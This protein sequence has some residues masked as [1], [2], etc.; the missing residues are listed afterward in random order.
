M[1]RRSAIASIAGAAAWLAGCD[2]ARAPDTRLRWPSLS[3][4]DLA[5]RPATLAGTSRGARVINV[6]AL[7]CPPCR[8]ELP[9]LERLKSVLAPLAI[10]VCTVALAEDSFP[11]REYLAQHA[12]HLHCVVLSPRMPV[13]AELDVKVLPQTF[14]VAADGGVL[15][16]WIGAREWDSPAVREQLDLLL[17]PA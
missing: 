8:R 14:L 16:R 6:W 11:V 4:R 5:G 2:G 3:V 1:R 15:A 7:W 9:S 13:V 12:A 17:Q 10:D